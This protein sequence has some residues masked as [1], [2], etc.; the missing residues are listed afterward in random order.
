VWKAWKISRAHNDIWSTAIFR[1]DRPAK[2][3]VAF[4]HEDLDET[5]SSADRQQAFRD[6]M[7]GNRMIDDSFID[8][9]GATSLT[10]ELLKSAVL[11]NLRLS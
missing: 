8:M 4:G 9:S 10:P 11:P 3:S 7:F 1:A 2:L 6:K 5:T